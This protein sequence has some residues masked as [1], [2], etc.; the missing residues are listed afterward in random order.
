MKRAIKVLAGALLWLVCAALCAVFAVLEFPS[1]FLNTRT[2][3]A[4][5]ERFGAS[6]RPR[7]KDL[8]FEVRSQDLL[9]K[10][11]ILDA[12]DFCFD[13]ETGAMKGCFALLELDATIRLGLRP[14]LRVTRLD[15]LVVRESS[16]S[17]DAAAGKAARKKEKPARYSRLPQ[18][19]PEPLRQMRLGELDVRLPAASVK[20]ASGTT[21]WGLS[22][23]YAAGSGRPLA[24]HGFAV[25]RDTSN[26]VSDRY[27]ADLKF[28]SD[29]FDQGRLSYLNARGEVRSR[30]LQAYVFAR[31]QNAGKRS[32][33][34]LARARVRAGGRTIVAQATGVQTPRRYV[35]RGALDLMDP[36]GP[37]RK[38]GLD[39]CRFQA[40]LASDGVHPEKAE[41][42]CALTAVPKPLGLAHHAKVLPFRGA[43]KAHVDF[44]PKLG[45]LEKDAFQAAVSADVGPVKDYYGFYL[46]AALK[47]A[48]RTSR[49]P[50]SLKAEHSV[51]AGLT[52][53]RF[54]DLVRYLEGTA[55]SVPAPFHVLDGPIT[56]E[57]R[58]V[59][60]P[61]GPDQRVEYT[62]TTAL[63]A[64][65][66]ALQAQARGAVTARGLFQPS[67]TFADSTEV[68]LKKVAF[69]LPYLRVGPMPAVSV[70]K[71]IV[72]GGK[73]P[74][75]AEAAARTSVRKSSVTALRYDAHVLTSAPVLLYSNVVKDPVPIGLDLHLRNSGMTGKIE[76]RSFHME[77]FRQLALIDHIT[78]T[79]LPG[80][81]AFGLDGLVVYKKEDVT[82]KIA[83]LGS[84]DRPQISL[85]SDPPMTQ[86]EIIGV[87]LYG[88]SPG[89]L[90]IDQQTS[91][92]NAATAMTNGA[93]GLASLYLFASTPIEYVGYDPAT[94]TYSIKFKLPGG[95][96][97]AVGS[98]LEESRT[99]KLRK[100][101]A[102][103]FAIETELQSTRSGEQRSSAIT[104]FLQ[105]FERY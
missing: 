86:D 17:I 101:I 72:T 62:L 45:A 27:V 43:F 77:V 65:R 69:E 79:P 35:A 76:L 59:G 10:R 55:Y 58:S 40:P 75:Q 34:L 19:L 68:D 25:L 84:T 67:P 28:D 63:S 18:L 82:I 56:F 32:L 47:L 66:Q 87:L 64:G 41:L 103:H 16:L 60:D 74:Q 78:L 8:S 20:T 48:G 54:Q 4:A 14:Y 7:W 44:K 31:A 1:G 23:R 73:P 9:T 50:E 12:S 70:D 21:T 38:L 33:K 42:V 81:S 36:S 71:R 22:A 26:L 37:V 96:T 85:T 57:A 39:D 53:D 90:D 30:G 94:Q 61:R 105:F 91:V 88:K 5:V 3:S 24:A 99:I 46:H 6:Y 11:L 98:T 29:L 83:L 13:D 89:E 100:R 52:V 95:A 15:K 102:S 49:L 51:T 80:S 2:L 104:T 92:G 93:F 97:L